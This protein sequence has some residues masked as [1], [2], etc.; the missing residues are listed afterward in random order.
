MISVDIVHEYMPIKRAP[1]LPFYLFL[2]CDPV[3]C[4]IHSDGYSPNLTFFVFLPASVFR[5]VLFPATLHLLF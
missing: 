5:F 3:C 4:Y 1:K 2:A